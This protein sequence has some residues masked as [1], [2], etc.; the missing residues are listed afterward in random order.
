MASAVEIQQKNKTLTFQVKSSV[1]KQRF[2]RQLEASSSDLSIFF[3]GKG[4]YQ[5]LL[6]A[7]LSPSEIRLVQS[8]KVLSKRIEDDL[9][10]LWITERKTR[11]LHREE[12]IHKINQILDELYKLFRKEHRLLLN[13]THG[14][15]SDIIHSMD[16]SVQLWLRI[17]LSARLDFLTWCDSPE[18]WEQEDFLSAYAFLFNDQ[19]TILLGAYKKHCATCNP[20]AVIDPTIPFT[21]TSPCPECVGFE[22]SGGWVD[23]TEGDEN[24]ALIGK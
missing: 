6:L 24:A 17:I 20:T 5:A 7:G 4:G 10:S 9:I 22:D 2:L 3:W 1:V 8:G 13:G 11:R 14:S 19:Y 23:A 18:K 15:S 16:G 21:R 12:S